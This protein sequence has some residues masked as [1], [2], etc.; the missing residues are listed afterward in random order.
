LAKALRQAWVYAGDYSPFRDRVHGRPP[1]G[2]G[3]E[4]FVVFLQNHDQVGNRAT[5]ERITQMAGMT[6][7]RA[8]IGA[9]LMILAPFVPMLFQ[10]EEWAASS[11]FLYFTDH[12]DPSL[13][14]AVSQGRRREFASFG[15]SPESVPDPQDPETFAR[16]KLN[17][18][19][20]ASP[21][22]AEML[23]WYRRLIALR[24]AIPA[25]S[26][27]RRDQVHTSFDADQGYL[28]V[29]RGPVT[30][31]VN[32]G[33]DGATIPAPGVAVAVSDPRVEFIEGAVV[34]P[35]DTVAVL[36][37]EALA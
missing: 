6:V 7:G 34:L 20:M 30:V 36:L 12:Q 9:A 37:D 13:A 15:W 32:L 26:D 31:V 19:E 4:R 25:L 24:R 1:H 8:K 14:E 29:R 10:G 5:G 27:G 11:P 3:G 2:L 28:Q 21:P 18:D 33:T 22:H 17:W 23:A 35:P 16:S